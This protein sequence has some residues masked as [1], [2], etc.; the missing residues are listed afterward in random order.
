V[1]RN[2]A[3]IGEQASE[4]MSRFTGDQD[5]GRH[6]SSPNP[7][8]S[9][10]RHTKVDRCG[11][12]DTASTQ[13]AVMLHLRFVIAIGLLSA[14]C[15]LSEEK[16]VDKYAQAYCEHVED[17]G[18][19]SSLHDTF[20]KC[21]KKMRIFADEELAPKGCR[22]N[23]KAAKTCLQDTKANE[24]CSPSGLE[25]ESCSRVASCGEDTGQ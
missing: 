9:A 17:C 14:G 13:E 7:D 10:A 12:H 24:D 15:G 5:A 3:R 4:G 19:M 1:D 2:R 6:G 22:Y 20:E 8:I 21:V 16:F 11:P 23:P 18:K 25:P